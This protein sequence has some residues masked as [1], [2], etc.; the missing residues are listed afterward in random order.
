VH[1]DLGNGQ[2]WKFFIHSLFSKFSLGVRG[3]NEKYSE[4]LAKHSGTYSINNW[5]PSSVQSGVT[6]VALG[7]D[8]SNAAF[9]NAD[10]GTAGLVLG[11]TAAAAPIGTGTAGTFGRRTASIFDLNLSGKT[12]PASKILGETGA[13]EAVGWVSGA[14]ELKLAGDVGAA[15]AEMLGCIGH[16]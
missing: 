10:E 11:A 16:P 7:N 5:L 12:G 13:K 3:Q 4:C 6:K 14:F 9:G 8:V 2:G 1:Q 15:A